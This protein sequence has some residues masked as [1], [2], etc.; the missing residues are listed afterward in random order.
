MVTRLPDGLT[1]RVRA[2]RERLD[3][4][5]DRQRQVYEGVAP[6]PGEAPPSYLGSEPFHEAWLAHES[7]PFVVRLA[8]AQAAWRGSVQPELVPGQL[9]V[10]TPPPRCVISYPTGTYSWDFQVDEALAVEHPATADAVAYW[11]EWLVRRPG[12]D[13][14]EEAGHPAL[15]GAV[16]LNCL[17]AHSV[18]AYDLALEGGLP[19]LGE[20]VARCRESHPEAADWYEALNVCLDGVRDYILAHA[21]DGVVAANCRRIAEHAP[22]TF[23]QAVQLFEFLFLLNGHDS[24]GRLDQVLWP[25]LQREL[26]AGALD[27]EQAQEVVD[28]LYLKLAE[29]ICYGST[30]GGQLP[31][32]GDATNDL[33]W[34]CLN[35]IRRLRLL[36]PRTALRWH[37]GT[38]GPLY[39]AAVRSMA[40]GATFPTLVN[41]EAL[42]PSLLRRGVRE[43]HARDYTFCG[44]GQTIPQGRAYG[45]YEDLFS[46]SAKFL[47]LALNDG[48]DEVS[49][50]Q[51]GPTTGEAEALGDFGALEDAVWEQLTGCLGVGIVAT[52]ATRRWAA[53][54]MPDFLRSLT[55]HSCVERGLDWRA[56][57]ADY[58]EG[59]VDLVGFTTLADSLVAIRQ[60][61]FE[62]RRLTLPELRDVLAAN[63]A[64][65][66]PLRQYCLTRAPKFGNDDP[67]ADDLLVR[68]LTRANDWLF[69]QET[70]RGGHWGLD[71]VGWSGA[72][73]Y[74]AGTGATPDG[75]R[76]G[77]PLADCGGPAQGRDRSGVTAVLRSMAKLPN[78]AVHGPMVLNLRF[79]GKLLRDPPGEAKL[80]DLLRTYLEAGGQ[81]VQVTAVSAQDM[82]AAQQEPQRY[83]N[84][85]VRV[86]GF[87]AY[88][89]ELDPAFQGDMLRRTEHEV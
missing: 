54:H 2:L 17:G 20:T 24:P 67:V 45:G 56:G 65:N 77:E 3:G 41:D 12:P 64:G 83:R 50:E 35:S 10:G 48:R 18:Q 80:A 60:V 89:V 51:A 87:S 13:L 1:P 70:W 62:E 59:L 34:L 22:E 40:G 75:R 66:E 78:D 5:R 71:I 38:P 44:C 88:F 43:D 31:G 14:P 6:K 33:T 47:T 16:E 29:H 27:L 32:G 11:R 52:N 26:R 86:G 28:C 4:L 49:G 30:L 61:V 63:W 8:H 76:A 68:W 72:V 25:A 15:R 36:S 46:N 73:V 37:R 85:M 81:Q 55:T 53:Q 39:R 57:G 21:T 19:G 69:A 74:G 23:L 82:R 84:L 42:V 9:I 79:P 58:H 7:D